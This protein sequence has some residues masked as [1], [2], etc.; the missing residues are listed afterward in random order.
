MKNKELLS[1]VDKSRREFVGK[2]VKTSVFA[3]PMALGLET[4]T[5]R[6]VY[7]QATST[8]GGATSTVGGGGV[9]STV[10]SVPEPAAVGL[11]GLGLAAIALQARNKKKRS[12]T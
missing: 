4:L 9:S 12:A 8:T 1:S 11:L 10:A 2:L 7:A 3:V 6:K 5:A